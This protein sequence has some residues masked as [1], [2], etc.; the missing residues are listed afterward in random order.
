MERGHAL[1]AWILIGI[2]IGWFARNVAKSPGYGRPI[3]IATAL[4]GSLLGGFLTTHYSFGAVSGPGLGIS[5]LIA[6]F[7]AVAF[8]FLLR[9][10]ES[11]RHMK[12]SP[13]R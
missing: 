13:D 6:A 9:L 5:L 7:G 10:L 8:T 1:I 12:S 3:D 4:T 2:A 11:A